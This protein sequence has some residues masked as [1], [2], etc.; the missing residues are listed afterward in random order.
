MVKRFQDAGYAFAEMP[1]SHYPRRYGESQF[2]RPGALLRTARQLASLWLQL[3][4]R[5]DRS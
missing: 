3:V 2:F 5:K 4:L 1:V